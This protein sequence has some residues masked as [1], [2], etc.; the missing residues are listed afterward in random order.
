LYRHQ[1]FLK[2]SKCAFRASEVG[3]LGHIF[4]KDGDCMHNKKTKSMNDKNIKKLCGFLDLT[5]YYRK[6]NRIMEKL[7][8]H[9]LI[10]LKIIIL[11]GIWFLINISKI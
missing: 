5:S 4:V 2:H 3:Y 1:L 6:K 10:S 8:P 9:S 11:V 7:H